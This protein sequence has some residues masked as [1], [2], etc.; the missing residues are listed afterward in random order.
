M[1]NAVVASLPTQYRLPVGS[2]GSKATPV[3]LLRPIAFCCAEVPR[4][5]LPHQLAPLSDV[6]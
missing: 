3:A 1:S 5:A 2:L 6:T 4:I